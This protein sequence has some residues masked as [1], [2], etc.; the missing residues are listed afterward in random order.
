[1]VCKHLIKIVVKLTWKRLHLSVLKAYISEFYSRTA[2]KSL[3]LYCKGQRD[4]VP[5]EDLL[6]PDDP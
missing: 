5:T 4:R 1:M 6:A 2:S 3:S